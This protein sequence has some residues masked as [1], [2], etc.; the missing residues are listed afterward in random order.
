MTDNEQ[1]Q[2]CVFT[3]RPQLQPST[4][5]ITDAA[6][7]AA[8]MRRLA[9]LYGARSIKTFPGAHPVSIEGSDLPTLRT[10]PFLCSLKSDGVRYLLLLMYLQNEPR[11]IFINRNLDMFEVEC[12]AP[13]SYYTVE[14]GTLLDGELVWEQMGGK[15]MQ[16]FL[17]FDLIAARERLYMRTFSER[18]TRIHRHVLSELPAGVTPTSPDVDTLII[19][20][21]RIYLNA[22]NVRMAPKRFV[23][24]ADGMAMWHAR[25]TCTHR[26]DGLIL[27]GDTP[28]HSGT[29]RSQLKWKPLGS[30]TVDLRTNEDGAVMVQQR[31]QLTR[32]TSIKLGERERRVSVARNVLMQCIGTTD[33][34]L[35]CT[36]EIR[37]DEVVFHPTTTRLDKPTANELY[38]VVKT[39]ENVLEGLTAEQLFAPASDC[40]VS[41]SRDATPSE[42]EP[43]PPPP[44]PAVDGTADPAPI[45]RS[46]RQAARRDGEQAHRRRRS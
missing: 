36:C 32:I 24:L 27:V 4:S 39:L 44:P 45:R 16:L 37:D 28:V 23:P 33:V 19:D 13:E 14:G 22:H 41:T 29:D 30:I 31:G 43:P 17:V 5:R 40:E 11:A 18:L 10:R 25:S 21:D 26:N 9:Y 7:K 2:L 8:V 15:L 38:T 46:K 20:E 3:D 35:E 42:G 6:E 34:V 1:R 12:W